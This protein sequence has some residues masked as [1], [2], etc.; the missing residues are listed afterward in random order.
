MQINLITKE[1]LITEVIPK[2]QSHSIDKDLFDITGY[3]CLLNFGPKETNL[4]KSG[5]R[6]VA[7]YYK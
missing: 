6:G 1:M 5:I 3:H 4:G 2:K 7:I